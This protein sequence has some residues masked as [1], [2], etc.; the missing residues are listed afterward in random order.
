MKVN[1]HSGFALELAAYL[2]KRK[3]AMSGREFSRRAAAGTHD[4]WA[5]ILAGSKVMTTNDIKVA[6]DVLGITPYE[7][8]A[9]AREHARANV[10]PF[11]VVPGL[12]EDDFEQKPTGEHR[13]PKRKVAKRGPLKGDKAFGGDDEGSTSDG[14][15]SGA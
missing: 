15:E 9:E 13:T 8:V 11:P 3:G 12:T 2:N 1:A 6:A 10:I 4:H 7:F 14:G 5:K